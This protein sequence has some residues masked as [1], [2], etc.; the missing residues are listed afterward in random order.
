MYEQIMLG[1]IT[2]AFFAV[3]MGL[4]ASFLYGMWVDHQEFKMYQE[5]FKHA[6]EEIEEEPKDPTAG[7]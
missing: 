3:S 1:F 7:R 6:T 4:C 2:M 5:G